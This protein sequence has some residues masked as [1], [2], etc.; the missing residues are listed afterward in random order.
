MHLAGNDISRLPAVRATAYADA[1]WWLEIDIT[2]K[3]K[4]NG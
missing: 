2:E 1:L 4:R 3:E